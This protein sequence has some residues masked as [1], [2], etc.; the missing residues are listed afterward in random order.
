MADL[1]FQSAEVSSNCSSS[2][3][4]LNSVD[5][6]DELPS[7]GENFPIDG[8]EEMNEGDE[9]SDDCNNM[10]TNSNSK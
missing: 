7:D 1:S 6:N 3:K 4:R 8:D 9:D 5:L 10:H 2:R